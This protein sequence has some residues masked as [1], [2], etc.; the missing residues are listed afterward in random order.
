[1]R[2]FSTW[3]IAVATAWLIAGLVPLPAAAQVEAEALRASARINAIERSAPSDVIITRSS[4]ERANARVYDYLYEGDR[5][6]LA[7]QQT[8]IVIDIRGEG[9]RRLTA[10]R[11]RS[12]TLGVAGDGAGG[13]G[14]ADTVMT[15]FRRLRAVIGGP[16]L[17]VLVETVGRG[18]R[19]AEDALTAELA[20]AFAAFDPVQKVADNVQLIV[21]LW[22]GHVSEV[23]LSSDAQDQQAVLLRPF[24]KQYARLPLPDNF[25]SGQ[26]TIRGLDGQLSTLQIRRADAATVPETMEG[27]D[28]FER[29]EL[30]TAMWLLTD[31][32][33]DR[34]LEGFS[35]LVLLAESD[36]VAAEILRDAAQTDFRSTGGLADPARP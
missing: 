14:I 26:L 9:R 32:P 27:T 18:E 21:P 31:A 12:F 33:A 29:R 3:Q 36:F 22:S 13:A 5:I 6:D 23:A 2:G 25:V 20:S 16:R 15:T 8:S 10:E 30:A 17:P 28:S 34:R 4:G 19:V 1:M 35:R 24:G 7:G 11:N